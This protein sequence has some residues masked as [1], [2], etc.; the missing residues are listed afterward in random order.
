MDLKQLSNLLINIGS[1]HQFLVQQF[2]H[3]V[4]YHYTDLNGLNGIVGSQDLWLTNSRFSNDSEEIEHG[5]IVVRNATARRLEAKQQNGEE[6]TFLEQVGQQLEQTVDSGAYV[7]CF[8]FKDDLLSQWRSYG[9]N[10]TGVSLALATGA[11]Q[12]IAGP[13]MPLEDFGLVYLWRVFYN[14]Q[15]QEQIVDDCLRYAWEYGQGSLDDK[16]GLATAAIRFFVPT[17][18]NGAFA[19]EQEARLVFVPAPACQVPLRFRVARGMLV[20]YYSLREIVSKAGQA[21]WRL[22]LQSLRIGPSVNKNMN[23]QSARL[24][25]NQSGFET[26]PVGVSTTPYRG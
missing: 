7:C 22:P 20:P 4:V 18:K 2:E 15:K 14:V 21:H 16:A 3:P 17:F 23:E 11:F 10:G 1:P 24:V 9:A 13:D 12:Y 19:E 26:A 25:L 5:R 8:C 6:R